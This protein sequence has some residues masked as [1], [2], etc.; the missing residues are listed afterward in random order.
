MPMLETENIDELERFKIV[1]KYQN[2]TETKKAGF[3]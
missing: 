2:E 3:S 1:K